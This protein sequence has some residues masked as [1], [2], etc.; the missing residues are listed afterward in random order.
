[1]INLEK[2][3]LL[4][5]YKKNRSRFVSRKVFKN[6]FEKINIKNLVKKF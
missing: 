4:K 3:F 6:S 5:K 1:M 2:N